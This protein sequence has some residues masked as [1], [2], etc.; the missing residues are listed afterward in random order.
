MIDLL[1]FIF[2]YV[3]DIAVHLLVIVGVFGMLVSSFSLSFS[4]MYIKIIAFLMMLVGIYMEGG[5]AVTKDYL[6][7]QEKWNSKIS[8]LEAKSKEV[9]KEIEYVYMDRIKKVTEVKVIYRDRLKEISEDIDS[10][11]KISP[12]TIKLVNKSIK[13]ARS[14]K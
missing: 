10:K 8:I 2:K 6:K 5:L 14:I 4:S 11:C 3:P 13:D 7:K 9:N 12:D 1:I